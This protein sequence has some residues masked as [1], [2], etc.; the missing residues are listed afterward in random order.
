MMIRTLLL[1][2]LLL[3]KCTSIAG[4]ASSYSS[5]QEESKEQSRN[6]TTV[7]TLDGL[8][9][10]ETPLQED[11]TPK[12][13]LLVQGHLIVDRDKL[14]ELHPQTKK[15]ISKKESG[16]EKISHK[17]TIPLILQ[18][19]SS[20]G[21]YEIDNSNIKSFGAHFEP[22]LT[23]AQRRTDRII[24]KSQ[25]GESNQANYYQISTHAIQ[26]KYE[27][28]HC[29]WIIQTATLQPAFS[30]DLGYPVKK[31]V[32][33]SRPL[34]GQYF[35]A[36]TFPNTLNEITVKQIN[37]KLSLSPNPNAP[38][39]VEVGGT[40]TWNSQAISMI[41]TSKNGASSSVGWEYTI[42]ANKMAKSDFHVHHEWI[43]LL[44]SPSLTQSTSLQFLT[45]FEVE[46]DPGF[47]KRDKAEKG[48]F[49][50]NF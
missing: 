50:L 40:W 32:F 34:N 28:D 33:S 1:T 39:G 46:Y 22:D 6:L 44:P 19:F 27:E 37:A 35:K 14:Q 7:I 17:K 3:Y 8:K 18:P 49:Q 16:E 2:L 36:S 29:F 9:I 12:G 31:Y 38:V 11:D 13:I 21:R 23:G 43:W 20:S 25:I 45:T 24:F 5:A 10:D 47:L 41:E 42:N 26:C 4:L 48:S 15:E 30:K